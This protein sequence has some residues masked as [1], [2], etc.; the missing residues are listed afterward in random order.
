MQALGAA[1]EACS[2]EQQER[3]RGQHGNNHADDPQGDAQETGYYE[4]TLS[5]PAHRN[6]AYD[7]ARSKRSRLITLFHAATKSRTSFSLASSLA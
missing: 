3:R 5:Q 4:C 1:Q 7:H 6:D 2:R